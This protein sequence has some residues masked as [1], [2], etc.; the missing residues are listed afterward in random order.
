L[1]QKEQI[2]HLKE[3]FENTM[4]LDIVIGTQW[5]DEGKGRLVDLLSSQADIVAR[6]NGGDNAGHTVTI[7]EKIFKLH[8]LPSG[9]IHPHTIGILGNGMVINPSSFTKRYKCLPIMG[10]IFL[11]TDCLFLMLPI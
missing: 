4:P 9:I 1:E 6:Y 8:L 7:K 2:K 5:G 10:L 3:K 11:L